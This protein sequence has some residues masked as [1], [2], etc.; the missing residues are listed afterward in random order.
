MA[1]IDKLQGP[2]W[3]GLFK[4]FHR[5]LIADASGMPEKAEAIYAATMQDT[6]AGGAAPET[7]MRNAQAYASFLARK[8]DKDKALSVLDQAE[9]FA[10][11]RSARVTRLRLSL[12]ARRT[13]RRRSCLI[14]PRRSIAAVASRSYGFTCSMPW[15]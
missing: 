5:A 1:S 8:G 13:A 4:S 3:F 7:W 11:T 6:A 2:D 15:P 12:P 14:S 10:P 9:A